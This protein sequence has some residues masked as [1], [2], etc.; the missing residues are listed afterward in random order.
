M[1]NVIIVDDNINS[2]KLNK[3]NGICIKAFYGDVINDKNTLRILGKILEKIRYDADDYYGGDITK[4]IV[5]H[6]EVI[7]AHIT[8][9]LG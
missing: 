4:S 7:F 9:N 8:T 2:F 6:K 3:K 5:K 1:K